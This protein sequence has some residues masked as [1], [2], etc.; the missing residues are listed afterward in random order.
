MEVSDSITVYCFCQ[1][2]PSG[3]AISPLSNNSDP[4]V[5]E[6]PQLN[7]LLPTTPLPHPHPH[8][9]KASNKLSLVQVNALYAAKVL[10]DSEGGDGAKKAKTG[11]EN[12]L[13]DER[14]KTMFEDPAFAIDE[15]ADEYKVLHPNAGNFQ[16]QKYIYIAYCKTVPTVLVRPYCRF[17]I[18]PFCNGIC[19][20]AIDETLVS[21]TESNF[22]RKCA[23]KGLLHAKQKRI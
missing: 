22:S 18:I 16:L 5:D 20:V 7:F 1:E 2:E 10:A 11:Q 8:L 4:E 19:S 15:Q 3:Q 17:Q 9:K 14:F 12:V 6:K 21:D 13:A 23:D